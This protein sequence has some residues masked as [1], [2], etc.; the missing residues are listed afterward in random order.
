MSERLRYFTLDEAN[1]LLPAL[2]DKLRV[3]TDKIR[4][5][6]ELYQADGPEGHRIPDDTR[7]TGEGTERIDTVK[8]EIEVMID[9]ILHEGIEVKGLEPAL[10]DF[11][12]L[13]HGTEVF[14]CWR[15]GEREIT[16]WHPTNTGIA[17]RQRLDSKDIWEYDN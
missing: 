8:A 13:R 12:A 7:F 9:E 3:I 4:F 5:A 2:V 16:H 17:G 11:P 1:A 15:E 14:L 10:L 6:R